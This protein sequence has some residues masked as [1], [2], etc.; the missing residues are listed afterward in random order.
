[1]SAVP[2]I[3]Q[4]EV[5]HA[6]DAA[7]RVVQAGGHA[8]AEHGLQR[9]VDAVRDGLFALD[10]V[11]VVKG[12]G[13]HRANSPARDP[14][15]RVRSAPSM[16]RGCDPSER[17]HKFRRAAFDGNPRHAVDDAGRFV[18]GDGQAAA[19]P[20]PMQALGAV[21][22]HA[23]QQ[24]GRDAGP[25]GHGFEQR[26]HRW[27]VSMAGGAA[28]SRQSQGSP[29]LHD[30]V[31][32]RI[33]GDVD[34]T[35]LQPLRIVRRHDIR[36]KALPIEARIMPS[37]KPARMCCTTSVGGQSAGKAVSTVSSALTPPVDAPSAMSEGVF[38]PAV[39]WARMR[40]RFSGPDVG[41][42]SFRPQELVRQPFGIVVAAMRNERNGLPKPRRRPSRTIT[43]DN[44]AQS[45]AHRRGAGTCPNPCRR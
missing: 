45:K 5:I 9:R 37:T 21:C 22:T 40:R 43:V 35:R 1:M 39:A 15:A 28:F 14:R 34:M 24:G 27:A 20:D 44:E 6:A 8:G 18:L 11:G 25:A 4:Q 19:R 17:K 41:T 12:Q 23:G 3:G 38:A 42:R 2:V 26:I 36:G 13:A 7:H 31:P 10:D 32:F 29:G 30:K 33:V 16:K